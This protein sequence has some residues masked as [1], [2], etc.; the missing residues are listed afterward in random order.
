MKLLLLPQDLCI[1]TGPGYDE[2]H[3]VLRVRADMP[4][5]P[6]VPQPITYGIITHIKLL[7][8]SAVCI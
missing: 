8:D 6:H 4:W 5:L 2:Q 1:I 3:S 7:F